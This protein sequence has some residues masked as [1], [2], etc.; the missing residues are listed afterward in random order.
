MYTPLYFSQNMDIRDLNPKSKLRD[1]LD[2]LINDPD[3]AL[4][5]L[6]YGEDFLNKDYDGK[7]KEVNDFIIKNREKMYTYMFHEG[8]S[9]ELGSEADHDA[10]ADCLLP[11]ILVNLWNK[12]KQ[13]YT[14][15]PEL[16]FALAD[17]EEVRVPVR[18]LDRL[19]YRTFYVQFS[20]E[21]I[22]SSNFHGAFVHFANYEHGY[23]MFLM[24]VTEDGKSSTG[25]SVFV[26]DNA[27][28]DACFI[29]NYY[30]DVGKR[31][32]FGPNVDWPEF[33]MFILNAVLYLCSEN[34]EIRENAV[35]KRTY[36]PSKTIK[37]KFSEVQMYD[38]G[39]VYG[40]TVRMSKKEKKEDKEDSSE[41]NNPKTRVSK[42]VRPHTRKAH[43]HHYWVGK[44]RKKLILK[45]IAPTTVGYG[46]KIAT[47]HKCIQ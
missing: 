19:P 33:S 41:E 2:N 28:P 18:I 10:A 26:P 37:N 4:V 39:Y 20:E 30:E 46:E 21:G 34:A 36:K 17:I 42:S 6:K 11:Y 44:G 31:D 38:C 23:V 14:F 15:D 1:I 16:E 8:D 12:N 5:F 22:F 29:V 43:W 24:R 3:E 27:D 9:I 47:I 13:V 25:T 45:W 35:T 40:S 7:F 32:V